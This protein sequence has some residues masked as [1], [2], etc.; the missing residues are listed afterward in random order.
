MAAQQGSHVAG[1]VLG[2]RRDPDRANGIGHPLET[3]AVE[4][5][6]LYSVDLA[7]EVYGMRADKDLSRTAARA[8][9]RR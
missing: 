2:L 9:S 5:F 7:G 8:Q 3:N 1:Y 6:V 4:R